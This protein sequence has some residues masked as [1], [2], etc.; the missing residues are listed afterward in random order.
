MKP[1]IAPEP[2]QES[3]SAV[4]QAVFLPV[5]EQGPTG[6]LST[7]LP[8]FSLG[9]DF[10]IHKNSTSLRSIHFIQEIRGKI[11]MVEQFLQKKNSE[12][13]ESSEQF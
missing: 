11:K 13:E 10:L 1:R 3:S 7:D 4:S 9:L 6:A 8:H 2:T 5:K 12:K